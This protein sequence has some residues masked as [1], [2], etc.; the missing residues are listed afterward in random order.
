M[1]NTSV[2]PLGAL[3]NLVARVTGSRDPFDLVE[4]A[5]G[6][7][8]R[9]FF[10]VGLGEGQSAVAMYV[11][12]P[13]QEIAKANEHGRRWPFLE[14]RDL[15]HAR[16]VQVP[17]IFAEACDDGL[18]L[19]EDLGETLAQHLVHSPQ[20]R[21]YL[22]Q[23]AVRDLAEAQRAL[24]PL[25]HGSI[26]LERAFDEDLLR[27]EVDHFREWAIE[28]RGL[29]F[30]AAD[31]AVFDAAATYLARTIAALPRGF[32][33][34]DY[35]SRNLM[36][37]RDIESSRLTLAWIDFQDAMLGPRVYDMVALLSDSYQQFDADFIEA[38]LDEFATH[39]ELSQAERV[40]LGR[41][42]DM[43][44]VQRK[45]KDAGRFVFIDR[46]NQN[47]SFL[48]FVEPTI[49]K[50]RSSLKRLQADPNLHALLELL[51]RVCP[52]ALSA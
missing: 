52:P 35:Q 23:A 36:V 42:F 6:A 37:V 44:T 7:S 3:Q 40:D 5:G 18:L 20:D 15:L 14:I 45:L 43:V 21:T 26:I 27:W 34:R 16:G 31:R 24:W 49:E 39:L 10:R 8:T 29:A 4:M 47:P 46:K 12:S 41:E 48:Q 13:S 50:A 17:K 25:P 11:P 2:L 32:V 1:P 19:V 33:H 22:Y 30:S 51:N 28:A 9:K 38:R